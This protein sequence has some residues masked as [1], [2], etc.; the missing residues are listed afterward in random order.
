MSEQTSNTI[1]LKQPPSLFLSQS[2]FDDVHQLNHQVGDL[3]LPPTLA[4]L[5]VNIDINDNKANTKLHLYQGKL[6]QNHNDTAVSTITIDKPTLQML[7][8]KKDPNI[9][10]E[11]FFNG[12][13]RIDGDLSVVLNLKTTTASQEQKQ[14]FKQILSQTTFDPDHF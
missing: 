5:V 7:I 4:Q 9:A 8:Q 14:L 1:V 3:Y 12:K 6:W 13:I 10:L 11:A 2:W